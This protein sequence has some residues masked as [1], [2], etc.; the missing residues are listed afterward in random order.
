MKNFLFRL[1]LKVLN[2]H[3]VYKSIWMMFLSLFNGIFHHFG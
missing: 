2:K 1:N 3:S